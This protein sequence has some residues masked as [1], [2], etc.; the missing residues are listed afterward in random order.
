MSIHW[1][2]R[3]AEPVCV[4]YSWLGDTPERLHKLTQIFIEDAFPDGA[5]YQLKE[6]AR[7]YIDWKDHAEVGNA[8][9]TDA[10]RLLGRKAAKSKSG[11]Y[12]MIKALLGELKTGLDLDRM[13]REL[14]IA[15]RFAQVYKQSGRK[16]GEPI[17]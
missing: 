10:L 1:A 5:V 13:A 3:G 17:R 4:T 8:I 12:E 9:K 16:P 2:T 7:H 11:V 6:M 15:R 14:V